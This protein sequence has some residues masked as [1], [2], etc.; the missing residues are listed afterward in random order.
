MRK[1]LEKLCEHAKTGSEV[2][3]FPFSLA[4]AGMKLSSKLGMSPLGDYHAL[5]YGRSMYFDIKKITKELKWNPIFSNEEMF[6]ESYEWYL[7]N[8]KTI[9]SSEAIG[10]HHQSKVRQGA[11]KFVKWIL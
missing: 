10:S 11:L 8:R 6:I 5:M 2:K 9:L 7:K 1:T 4:V 3:N